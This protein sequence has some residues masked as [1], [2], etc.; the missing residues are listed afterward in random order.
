METMVMWQLLVPW[1]WS[2]FV[3]CTPDHLHGLSYHFIISVPV[4]QAPD[5]HDYVTMTTRHGSAASWCAF[6]NWH[7]WKNEMCQWSSPGRTAVTM[8]INKT[9]DQP[10]NNTKN[11]IFTDIKVFEYCYGYILWTRCIFNI[12]YTCAVKAGTHGCGIERQYQSRWYWRK[13][14]TWFCPREILVPK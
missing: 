12:N 11:G 8:V 5:N 9:C 4:D 1:R 6:W 10:S 2:W 3:L 14:S 13:Y 7:D